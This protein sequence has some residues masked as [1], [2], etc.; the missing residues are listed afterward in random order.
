MSN[1][2]RSALFTGR[3]LAVEADQSD[4]ETLDRGRGRNGRGLWWSQR[5]DGE[6]QVV[7]IYQLMVFILKRTIGLIT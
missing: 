1:C 7:H 4:T 3:S 2:Q 5:C 6:M